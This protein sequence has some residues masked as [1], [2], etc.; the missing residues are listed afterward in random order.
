MN[1]KKINNFIDLYFKNFSTYK[2]FTKNLVQIIENLLKENNITFLSVT[3]RIKNIHKCIEKIK[4]KNYKNPVEDLLD[5]CGIRII[6]YFQKD[7]EAIFNLLEKNFQIIDNKKN[8]NNDPTK[9]GY[10]SKHIIIKLLDDWYNI[11]IFKNSQNIKVEVQIRTILMHAWAEIEHK[12][13]YKKE[14]HIPTHIRRKFSRLSAK[15]EESD[16]QFEDL[17][18]E[19]KQYQKT[20]IQLSDKEKKLNVDVETDLDTLQALLD[21]YLPFHTKNIAETR[22][23]LDIILEKNIN[24]KKLDK[25]IKDNPNKTKSKSNSQVNT[26]KKLI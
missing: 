3:Y 13:A 1:Q 14:S 25:I 5:L 6:C 22:N 26:I 23:L 2:A 15:L 24:I 4:R 10:R 17:M 7:I 18:A 9:F 8:I 11:P 16:E 21:F 20:L 19:I 12:L